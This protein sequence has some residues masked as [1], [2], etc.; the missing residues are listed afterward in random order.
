MRE[1]QQPPKGGIAHSYAGTLIQGMLLPVVAMNDACTLIIR[2]ACATPRHRIS[3]EYL[4]VKGL[5]AMEACAC[6]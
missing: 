3:L 5:L 4:N 6:M 2:V 1:G